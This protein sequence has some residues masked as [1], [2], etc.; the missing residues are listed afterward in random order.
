MKKV[1]FTLALALLLSLFLATSS[2]KVSYAAERNVNRVTVST[3]QNTVHP[4]ATVY[5]WLPHQI[6][7]YNNT[8]ELCFYE[9]VFGGTENVNI[10]NVTKVIR[11]TGYDIGFSCTNASY[12]LAGDNTGREH[13]WTGSCHMTGLG[14]NE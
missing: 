2:A 8:G 14:V 5:C 3:V 1:V 13:Q 12:L 7:V 4:N 10:Y 6:E 9:G 11:T